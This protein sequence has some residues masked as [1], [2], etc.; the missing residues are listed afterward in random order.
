MSETKLRP[1]ELFARFGDAGPQLYREA[2]DR[3]MNLSA[4]LDT[5]MDTEFNDGLDS[6]ERL[7]QAADICTVSQPVYGR[8]A[9]HFEK[10]FNSEAHRAL[11]PEWWARQYR[12]AAHQTP[13]QHAA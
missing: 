3:G 2:A 11:L 5:V 1:D 7:L 9:D 4:H 13:Q 10:F 12:K 8:Y 6:F